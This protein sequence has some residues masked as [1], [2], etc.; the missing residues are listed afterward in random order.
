MIFRIIKI[1]LR[2][3]IF[4]SLFKGKQLNLVSFYSV[5]TLQLLFVNYR[6]TGTHTHIH[7]CTHT[8]THTHKGVDTHGQGRREQRGR[9][10]RRTERQRDTGNRWSLRPQSLTK[11]T[12]FPLPIL[13]SF[14]PKEY[15]CRHVAE[16]RGR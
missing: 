16:Y 13:F 3:S 14:F 1:N 2:H 7:A 6:F 12:V 15:F 10:E 11:I 5:D 9:G 4:V 8:H